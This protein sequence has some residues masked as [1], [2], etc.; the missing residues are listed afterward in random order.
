MD[1]NHDRDEINQKLSLS[2]IDLIMSVL[3][4]MPFSLIFEQMKTAL[5]IINWLRILRI[6]KLFPLY[7][8]CNYFKK[9]NVKVVR[10]SEIIIAYYV[11]SHISACVMLSVGLAQAHNIE[12][13][14]LNKVPIPLPANVSK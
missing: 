2:K 8:V 5:F 14:W 7:K 12:N 9:Y 11:V 6:S 10:I 4:L 1:S 13:T 3:A